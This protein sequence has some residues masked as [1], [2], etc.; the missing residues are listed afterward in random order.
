MLGAWAA[1]LLAAAPGAAGAAVW[2]VRQAWDAAADHR[3]T[4]WVREHFTAGIFHS[5]SPW[6][7]IPTDCAD[8]AYGMRILFAYQQG[9]PFVI[10]DP[11]NPGRMITQAS[12]RFDHIQAGVPRVR[13][14]LNWVMGVTSTATLVHDTY[15]IRIDREQIRPGVIFLTWKTHVMQIVDLRPTGVVTYVE[16]T[17]PRAIREMTEIHGFPFRVPADPKAGGHGD[18]FRRFKNPGDYGRPDASLPGYGTEQFD[19]AREFRREVLPFYEWMQA[20]LAVA[21]EPAASRVRR[22]LYTLCQMA[23]DRASAIDEGQAALRELR[24]RSRRCMNPTE[25]DE[26][27]TPNRDRGL[28]R[29]IEHL[30]GLT[31]EPW[32]PALS[33]RYREFTEL[34]AGKLAPEREAAVREAFLGWCNVNQVDGGPGRP[35]D[36]A[37]MSRLALDGRWVSDPHVSVARR[38]GLEAAP[39]GGE[40]AAE[41]PR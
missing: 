22:Q 21:P 4:D 23:W 18:G 38:W 17:T 32:W 30:V 16:S 28:L 20:R 15:P 41:C 1:V 12:T 5:D 35:M 2:Q 9:L 39:A 24:S 37:E 27:S 13:A 29:A 8:A 36:L 33:T 14:F 19:K 31:G 26:Y 34:I 3:F 6:A 11:E 40:R 10:R 25:Y 7:D